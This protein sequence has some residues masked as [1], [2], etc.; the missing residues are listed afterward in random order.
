MTKKHFVRYVYVDMLIFSLNKVSKVKV[1]S[2]VRG[3]EKGLKQNALLSMLLSNEKCNFK[4]P[5]EMII[6]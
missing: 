2:V 1:R 5:S 4:T 6:P 3:E